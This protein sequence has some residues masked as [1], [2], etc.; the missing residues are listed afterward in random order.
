MDI[1][2]TDERPADDASL[3]AAD[4]AYH[5]MRDAILSGHLAAGSSLNERE[6]AEKIGV[7]RTPV[8]EAL[9]RLEQQGMAKSRHNAAS[10]VVTWTRHDI[11]EV[12]QIR[13][14]LEGLVASIAAT[15][16]TPEQT[17][18]LAGLCDAMEGAFAD[19]SVE[20]T[21]RL[22]QASAGNE[23]FHKILLGAIESERL[24]V[25]LSYL[26]NTPFSF[27]SYRWFSDAEVLRSMAHHRDIVGALRSQD[28]DWAASSMRAHIMASRANLLSRVVAA[29]KQG[30]GKRKTGKPQ[31][32][33]LMLTM[34]TTDGMPQPA[35]AGPVWPMGQ[36][37]GL[38][39]RGSRHA[40][41]GVHAR[42]ETVR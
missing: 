16:A 37:S 13:A 23:R 14:T 7:S 15:R 34:P 41:N 6:L 24:G 32:D 3:S 35:D 2:F 31:H 30:R 1:Q 39:G 20:R 5:W 8:R 17:A 33:E 19:H 4:R 25:L 38:S 11:H 21:E 40:S 22:N 18:E 10:T 12:F 27:R 9:R 29:P 36:S 28:A 26:S 42:P